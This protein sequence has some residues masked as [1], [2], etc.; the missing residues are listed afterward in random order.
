M[1]ILWKWHGNGIDAGL[2]AASA[3]L[4]L[5]SLLDA[6]P[7]VAEPRDPDLAPHEEGREPRD[8]AYKDI[9]L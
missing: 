3:S 7:H 6:V 4:L 5:G 9:Y 8:V 1:E 2:W